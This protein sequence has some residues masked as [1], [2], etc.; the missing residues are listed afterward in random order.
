MTT[1]AQS[2]DR[3]AREFEDPA[4]EWRRIFSEGWGMFLIV[5]FSAGASCVHQQAPTEVTNAM[6][7]ATPAIVVMVSIYFVGAIGGAHLNPV[8][9]LAFALRQNFPW[10]RVPGYLVAQLVGG[11]LAGAFLKSIFGLAGHLGATIP[12]HGVSGLRALVI[13]TV[14]MAGFVNVIL[15]TATGARNVGTNVAIA[16]GGYRLACGFF[17]FSLTG[18]SLNP[19]RS[20]VPDLMRDDFTTTWIY[21]I[22]PFIGG[23]LAVALEWILVGPPT[24]HAKKEAQ[25]QGRK[26][27]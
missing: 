15:A 1:H 2:D 16:I 8:V 19:V 24:A 11:L 27:N 9:T 6:A 20:F 26:K 17:A 4:R 10:R 18:A 21:L 3:Q 14:M 7:A 22:A 23:A 5:L 13:E 25:G 12:G